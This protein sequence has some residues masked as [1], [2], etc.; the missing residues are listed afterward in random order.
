MTQTQKQVAGALAKVREQKGVS[1]GEL[2]RRLSVDRSYISALESGTRNPSLKTL[3]KVASALGVTVQDIIA[4]KPSGDLSFMA[5]YK[6]FSDADPWI[7]AEEI[8]DI[9]FF[10]AQIWM[11]SFAND[12]KKVAGVRYS[13]V[14]SVH[15][16][17]HLRFYFGE[18][19]AF[20][21]A[22]FLVN[23][24]VK[25]PGLVAEINK[26]IVEHSDRLRAFAEKLPDSRLERFSAEELWRFY[27][28]HDTLH[29]E[30]Y[31]WAWIPVSADMFHSNLTNLLTDHLK[32]L[33][34]SHEE[35]NEAF[36][37]LTQPREKSLIQAE[38]D[39]FLSLAK[40]IQDD[41]Y[42]EKLFKD[43]FNLFQEKQAAP[44]GLKT[45]TPEYEAK[46]EEKTNLIRDQIKTDIYHAIEEH[47]RKY[48]YVKHMWVGKEGVHSFDYYL[49][50]LVKFVGH[51]SDARGL[52]L[53]NERNTR[54][55]LK[56]REVLLKKLK[57]S[58]DWQALF[59]GFG[60]FMVTK[61]YRRYAQIYAVYRMKAI[62]NEIA[63]RFNVD[64]MQVS[65]M[66]PGEVK[67]ALLEGKISRA[68]LRGRSEFCVYYTES[69]EEEIHTGE[70][71][72][73]LAQM[74]EPKKVE[75]VNEFKG[76]TGCI[77]KATGFV[78]I[79]T[80]PSDMAKMN[81]GDILVS[82]ATD[83]DIVPAMK[84]AAAIVTEQ[85]GVTSH[86]A[87][88]SRELKIPCVIGTKIA[89]KVLKDGDLVEVDATRGI[90]KKLSA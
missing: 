13:K 15:Q 51:N 20:N 37:V 44:F 26:K 63:R 41:P 72:R 56:K 7:L 52:L 86:A 10:F 55:E 23:R 28:E 53:E 31:E 3:E 40:M 14:I 80:R 27:E 25:E 46:L 81:Q 22:E 5:G 9:D 89:T 12:I 82:I 48:Y 24:F 42:H 2:A 62:Q 77:G 54:E 8:P 33:G 75:A 36:M 67:S 79:I 65:F 32:S 60:D 16:G 66:L 69:A 45:H 84:K 39:E 73:L 29:T 4:P 74:V 68:V 59:D 58:P 17:Y 35:S 18:K 30:Y 1:Q 64:L 61:I 90:V 11:S 50:E 43:L 83:P 6:N 21:V 70:K 78:K 71:A 34:L 88:V 85:G 57:L 76:Q 47:Y 87:I 19:S 49:K 38:Q